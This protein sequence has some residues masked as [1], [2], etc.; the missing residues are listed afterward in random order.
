MKAIE[1]TTREFALP[2]KFTAAV[3]IE[4]MKTEIHDGDELF[5]LKFPIRKIE[6]CSVQPFCWTYSKS[7]LINILPS[8]QLLLA[9]ICF[10]TEIKHGK[11]ALTFWIPSGKRH[12]AVARREQRFSK[13]RAE[14]WTLVDVREL[15]R[16]HCVRQTSTLRL[17]PIYCTQG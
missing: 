1:C 7:V 9:N 12:L 13:T 2:D 16:Q 5:L 3:S 11:V 14:F 4:E 8:R 17:Y 15:P 6:L 10:S